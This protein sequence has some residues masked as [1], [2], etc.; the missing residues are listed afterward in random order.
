MCYMYEGCLIMLEICFLESKYSRL[1]N[2]HDSVQLLP[3]SASAQMTNLSTDDKM[4]SSV[5]YHFYFYHR[6]VYILEM[7]HLTQEHEN[8]KI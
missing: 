6:V 2:N 1:T 8:S 7:V 5:P 4:H 3:F